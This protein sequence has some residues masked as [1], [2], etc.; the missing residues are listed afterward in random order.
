MKVDAPDFLNSLS[1]SKLESLLGLQPQP[2][3]L[4][5]QQE[6]ASDAERKAKQRAAARDLKIPNPANIDRRL[7]AEE[8]AEVWLRTYFPDTFF[9][10]F[11]TD[12]S[13]MLQAIVDAAIYGGD[14]AIAGARGEGKTRLAMYG[15]LYLMVRRLSPFVIVIG[16]NQKKSEG[17]LKTIRERLQQSEMFIADYPEIGI[18]F[19]AVGAWSS[20]ARMQTAGGKPTGIEMASD[21]IILPTIKRDQ[22]PSSW[23]QEIEPASCGQIV[24]SV[25]VDGSIRGTNYYDRRPSLAIIDDIED[26]E[27]AASDTLIG[28][29]EEIIEQDISGLGASGRLVSRL[30]LCTT[31]NRKSIAY[32]YT[33]PKL[34]PNWRGERFRMLVQKPDRMDLVQQYIAMRQER[35]SSDPDARDAFRFWRDNKDDIERGAAISNPYSFDQRPHADG[36]LLELSAVQAYYNKVADYGEKAVATEYDN[37]P[38]PETGPVGNGISADIVSSRIS[39]LARRQLPANTVS[40]TAAIDLGKY[41]CHWVICGWWKGA[42]GVVI[43]YGIAEVTGTD[44]TTDNEASEP[45]IYKALLR[46]R[47][48]MLSRPLVDASGE[49]RPIDFTLIDSGTFTNAAY[50]FCRQVG[51]KFH[52]SKGLANYK[53][54]RTASPTCIPGERLHAQ[55]LPPSKVWLYELDV[56]YWKQWVHERFLTPTFDENNMLRRG[57]LSLFHPDG[58]KKHLTF[59]QHIAAEE[60]VSEFKEGRGSKTFW[61][62]VNANNHFFDAL[63]M[64]SAATEVCKV[65][66]IGESESQV[67]ARQINADAPKPITNRAKPH[68]R[69]RTR[70]GGWIPQRRY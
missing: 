41:A 31:Q 25:G 8:S 60:L 12:R 58:N 52:P 2:E 15:G 7:T 40:V 55:F 27:A 16:K 49:E 67:S 34:K 4:T 54:R 48:E 32:K 46:W 47:D 62:C 9:Q 69:F 17:E 33:D 3:L 18:P 19:R 24:A 63:C 14:K 57:S 61:N 68:G 37:D 43:D 10:P 11:T 21:H 36:E 70:P 56:D 66:L 20:R 45:M 1:L 44:N 13:R 38:P 29:N 35:S 22:L 26:R 50:E 59:A 30:M 39:G 64:A 6:L 53:P 23:P 65:K 42:G 28:K 5:R 51:G